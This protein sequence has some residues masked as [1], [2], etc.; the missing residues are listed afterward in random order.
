MDFGCDVGS[1]YN[2]SHYFDSTYLHG[3]CIQLQYL[4]TLGLN[5]IAFDILFMHLGKMRKDRMTL[6]FI[7]CSCILITYHL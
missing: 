5:D 7:K 2:F 3:P 4:M 6:C 1:F